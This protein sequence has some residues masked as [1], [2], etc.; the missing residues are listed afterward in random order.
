MTL[1]RTFVVLAGGFFLFAGGLAVYAVRVRASAQALITSASE[2]RSAADAERQ[3]EIWRNLSGRRFSEAGAL[4]DGDHSYD[5]Q[6]ENGLLHRLHIAVPAEV[7]MTIT[8]R[9][10]ELRSVILVMFTGREPSTTAGVWVQEWFD[11]GNTNDIHVNSKDRPWKATVEFSS[12]LSPAQ[13]QKAFALNAGCL[14]QAGSCK[15]AEDMLPEVWQFG[16]TRP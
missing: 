13:R 16:S 7:G 12:T 14:V 1:R 3:I 6:V 10:G 11:S 5:I 9:S 2:I 4:E 8:M 15:S